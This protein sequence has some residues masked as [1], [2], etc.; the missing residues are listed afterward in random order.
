M[1]PP[2]APAVP[3]DARRIWHD[4]VQEGLED[5]SGQTLPH[6]YYAI[7]YALEHSEGQEILFQSKDGSPGGVG[8]Y[9][10]RR[11]RALLPDAT[12]EPA[13]MIH[14]VLVPSPFLAHR[15]ADDWVKCFLRTCPTGPGRADGAA[16]KPRRPQT[17]L[18]LCFAIASWGRRLWR[19]CKV[20][21]VE[22][23][24]PAQGSSGS[25]RG[26]SKTSFPSASSSFR[27]QPVRIDCG[28]RSQL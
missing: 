19:A 22:S 3:Q 1:P 27:A 10:L 6:G 7:G 18:P 23:K 16:M 26:G 9:L 15:A 20:M 11:L 24:T 17:D 2:P 4:I 12:L 5:L 13:I 14:T 21:S 28:P 25:G 8:T